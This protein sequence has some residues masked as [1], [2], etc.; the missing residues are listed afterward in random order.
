M[1]HDGFADFRR[2][3]SASLKQKIINEYIRLPKA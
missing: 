2:Q 1:D 3:R